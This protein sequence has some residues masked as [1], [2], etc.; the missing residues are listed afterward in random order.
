TGPSP[1]PRSPTGCDRTSSCR[2]GPGAAPARSLGI[3]ATTG[4]LPDATSGPPRISTLPQSVLST[5][6]CQARARPAGCGAL[7]GSPV[8]DAGRRAEHGGL[9]GPARL[10]AGGR[11]PAGRDPQRPGPAGQ[12]AALL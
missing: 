12:P 5:S 3:A 1:R 10:P 9:V 2:P 4:S 6:Y 11:G 8:R 7:G